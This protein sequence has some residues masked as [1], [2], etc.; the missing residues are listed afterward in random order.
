MSHISFVAFRSPRA[1]LATF[2]EIRLLRSSFGLTHDLS[3]MAAAAAI[4]EMSLAY[5]PEDE[6]AEKPFRLGVAVLEALLEGV[7]PRLV[8]TYV[9]FWTLTLSGLMPSLLECSICGNV[10]DEGFW[11]EAPHQQLCCSS[12]ASGRGARVDAPSLE[13]LRNC[14]LNP[15]NQLAEPPKPTWKWLTGLLRS[16]AE[17]SL[18]ALR[19]FEKIDE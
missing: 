6:P 8:V 1:E 5:F 19:F 11:F 10:L 12:C 9:M 13:F 17:R 4:A 18:K 3:S 7:N 2:R 14:R 15:V 16:E